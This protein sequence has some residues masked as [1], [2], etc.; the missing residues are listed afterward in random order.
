[1][2]CCLQ[3]FVMLIC[4]SWGCKVAPIAD[5]DLKS[6]PSEY[7]RMSAYAPQGL[8]QLSTPQVAVDSSFFVNQCTIAA[9]SGTADT[10]ITYTI[11]GSIPTPQSTLL[12]PML[13]L[14]SSAT[15][16]IRAF[17][18]DYRAS[19]I[20]SLKIRKLTDRAHINRISVDP[21]PAQQYSA[22]TSILYDV[23]KGTSNYS[24]GGRWLGFQADRITMDITCQGAHLSTLT[25]SILEDHG[26]WIFAPQ[27][28]Q[29]FADEEPLASQ[30]LETP[31]TAHSS[32]TQMIEV[33][34]PPSNYDRLRVV[35][36]ALDSIPPWHPGSGEMPWFFVDEVILE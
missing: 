9:S 8:I 29:V 28:I 16:N 32:N 36:K 15:V 7:R 20:V 35:V 12:G 24:Q 17:H 26:S 30:R 10:W 25:L 5:A 4:A 2:R 19:E 1:M 18:K 34:L 33:T 23:L 3:L 11:D 31:V 13:Q 21:A 14:Q 27:E 22:S 6:P